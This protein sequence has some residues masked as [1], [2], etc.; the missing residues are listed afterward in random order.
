V[1]ATATCYVVRVSKQKFTDEA[2][3]LWGAMSSEM[4]KRILKTALCAKC[5]AFVKIIDYHG[6]V[7]N[8]DLVLDGTCSVCGHAS[9]RVVEPT[10]MR[11]E[12]N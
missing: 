4:Q 7:E 11:H 12:N 10:Q 3:L 9:A 5:N 1:T 6:M 2:A 8:G